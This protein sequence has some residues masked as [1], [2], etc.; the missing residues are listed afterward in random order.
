ML[1]QKAVCIRMQMYWTLCV[2]IAK[3]ITEYISNFPVYLGKELIK[4]NGP[5]LN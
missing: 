2:M 4:K 5:T 1:F 3:E